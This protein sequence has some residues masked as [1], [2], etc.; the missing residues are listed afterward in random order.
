M[1]LEAQ[2]PQTLSDY[3]LTIDLNVLDHLGI[4]LYSNVAAVLTEAVAN[5][6]DADA[7]RVE[8]RFDKTNDSISIADDGVG[9]SVQDVNDKYLKVGYRRR[10]SGEAKTPKGRDV[11]GRK[12]L[13]KLSLFSIAETV[14]VTSCKDGKPHGFR[15]SIPEIKKAIDAGESGYS[16]EP[17]E[18]MD[19]FSLP[20]GTEIILKGLHKKR[21]GVTAEALRKKLARRFSVIGGE[22]FKVFVDGREV[23]SADRD[24]F[25]A[26]EFLWSIGATVK[27]AHILE[28]TSLDEKLEGWPTGWKVKGWIGTS[29]KPKDLSTK[30]GNLNSIVVLSRGRLFQEN[31]LDS[32]NDGRHYLNYITGQIEA[33]FLDDNDDED[34]ATSDRQRVQEDNERYQALLQYLKKILGKVEPKWN[35]WRKKH[36]VE[37]IVAEHPVVGQWFDSMP[38]GLKDSARQLVAKVSTIPVSDDEQRRELLKNS[39]VA[40]ERL[41]LHGAA[42]KLSEAVELGADALLPLFADQRDLEA[43]LYRDI[44][45]SRLD[46]IRSFKNLVDENEKERVLQEHLFENLWLLDPAWERASG[47]ELMESRLAEAGV[48]VEDLSEKEKLARVDIKYKT[49][50]GKHI[51]VE[52]KRAKRKMKLLELQEQ[53]QTYYDKLR[54]VLANRGQHNQDIEVIFVIGP[55]LEEEQSNPERVKRCM[56]SISAGSRIIHYDNL[57][58]NAMTSYEEYLQV[59]DTVGRISKLV[60]CL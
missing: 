13:G 29:N 31:I 56:E 6:W 20:K 48:I 44:V 2:Q 18:K 28:E 34:I 17:L 27:G 3:E 11:M 10:E 26:V 37:K 51:I 23:T 54:K 9:M 38:D 1:Y 19:L 4:N 49:T 12:G 32:I 15:M 59:T 16:P 35:E 53:G 14:E 47:S 33:D 40:F 45:S 25:Q 5:A 24:D 58:E 55:A 30:E 22:E 7:G 46:T 50:A 39:V 52:L 42:H 60:N 43:A 41:K 36:G 8:I 57:I 21:L